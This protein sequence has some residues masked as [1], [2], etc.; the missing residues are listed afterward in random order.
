MPRKKAITPE[1]QVVIDLWGT[2][3][4]GWHSAAK[5]WFEA[6]RTI[7]REWSKA[8]V[9]H[10][11]TLSED[12]SIYKQTIPRNAAMAK[13]IYTEMNEFLTTP[14]AYDAAVANRPPEE[15]TFAPDVEYIATF[16]TSMRKGPQSKTE[17]EK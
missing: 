15:T 10:A 2:T 16:M 9:A 5:E 3:P 7:P 6:L 13:V 11:R 1:E 17:A 14:K 8:E 4:A 12:L